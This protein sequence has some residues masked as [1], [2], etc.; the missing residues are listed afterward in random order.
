MNW[1][2]AGRAPLRPDLDVTKS[3]AHEA[4]FRAKFKGTCGTCGLSF[5]PGEAI[6]RTVEDGKR[7]AHHGSCIYR[8]AP[9]GAAADGPISTIGKER[10]DDLDVKTAED[11]RAAQRR[12]PDGACHG[13]TAK[14]LPCKGGAK[15]G[16]SF[17]GP[18]LDKMA[19]DA[20]NSP[21]K[22]AASTYDPYYDDPF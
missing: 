6:A 9:P 21:A 19:R 14:G 4:T 15:K 12:V 16:E 5:D 3:S 17:C 7:I 1:D 10:R 20:A 22:P 18:H 11:A 8:G 2:R 13:V